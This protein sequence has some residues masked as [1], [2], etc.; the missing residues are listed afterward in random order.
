MFRPVSTICYRTL[1]PMAQAIAV[2]SVDPMD[3]LETRLEGAIERWQDR[4]AGLYALGS[5]RAV[6]DVIRDLL[7][8]PQVRAVVFDACPEVRQWFS[9]VWDG[10]DVP[11]DIDAEHV[12]MVRQFVD[13]YDDDFALRGPQQPFSPTRV[14]YL[15]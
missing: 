2:I 15:R 12:T 13:L 3:Q 7:A 5:S 11:G 8:N 6:R 14:T 9:A 4:T 1:N 10:S